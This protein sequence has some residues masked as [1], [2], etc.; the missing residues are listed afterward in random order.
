M[1][2]FLTNISL[3]VNKN[4]LLLRFVV[5]IIKT[6]LF[7][8]FLC[9]KFHIVSW[10]LTF[11]YYYSNFHHDLKSKMCFCSVI[12]NLVVTRI[13]FLHVSLVFVSRYHILFEYRMF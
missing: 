3:S 12:Y 5:L 4:Y 10:T 11:L 7:L 8:N 9:N 1:S 6:F 13:L 2:F